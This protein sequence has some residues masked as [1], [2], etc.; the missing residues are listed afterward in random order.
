MNFLPEQQPNRNRFLMPFI[1]TASFKIMGNQFT[2]W[3]VRCVL[4]VFMMFAMLCSPA[5]AD[6]YTRIHEAMQALIETTAAMG[7][8]KLDHNDLYFGQTIVNGEPTIVD[9]IKVKYGTT[10]TLFAKKDSYFERITTNVMKD[11][12]RAL[13][14]M[15]DADGPAYRAISQGKSYYGPVDILGKPYDAGYEPIR[16]KEGIVIGVYYVGFARE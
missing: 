5:N 11:G 14:T 1:Q 15:L 10:A 8:P 16:N 12:Q 6:Q 9:A 2:H 4:A 13:G 3:L 7:T